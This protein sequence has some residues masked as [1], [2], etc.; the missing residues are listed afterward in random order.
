MM[1]LLPINEVTLQILLGF[2]TKISIITSSLVG[3][4]FLGRAVL[5]HLSFSGAEGYRE[6]ISDTAEYFVVILLFP[7][8]LVVL[9][10]VILSLAAKFHFQEAIA[11]DL[12]MTGLFEVLKERSYYF[13]LFEA[14]GGFLILHAAQ[15][16]STIVVGLLV[17][18][19]PIVILLN[20]MFNFNGGVQNYIKSMLSV[21]L[22][23]VLWNLLGSLAYEIQLTLSLT[24]L[25]QA[26]YCAVVVALQMFS[27]L[28]AY[29][30]FGTLSPATSIAAAT[31]RIRAARVL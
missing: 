6:L 7:K 12:S 28:F 10:E 11:L 1:P 17:A 2:F 3:L 9:N 30:L 18:I 25:M 27:P 23:P 16:F 4:L 24:S 15:G 20:T 8:L 21:M 19:G 22:W 29:A 31:A 14:F 26:V 13:K 5:L